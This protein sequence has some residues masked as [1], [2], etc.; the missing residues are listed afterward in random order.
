M[1]NNLLYCKNNKG[2]IQRD[3]Y[4]DILKGI[5]II[6]VVIGHV[7]QLGNDRLSVT[8]VNFIYS[9]HMPLFI[10][11]SGYFSNFKSKSYTKSIFR[12]LETFI[13]I[14]LI[15]S[16]LNDSINFHTLLTPRFALWY[17]LS[18][19][20]WKIMLLI[21]PNNVRSN[22]LIFITSSIILC[23]ASGLVHIST[24]L[25]FQRTFAFMPFFVVGYL[26]RS[27]DYRQLLHRIN[28]IISITACIFAFVMLFFINTNFLTCFSGTTFLINN[29]GGYIISRFL[30]LLCGSVMSISIMRISLLIK[31]SR[32]LSSIG[33]ASLHIY[34]F[35]TFFYLYL[36]RPLNERGFLPN[37]FLY[38][39]LYSLTIIAVLYLTSKVKLF[40]MIVNPI[41]NLFDIWKNRF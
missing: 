18:L 9:F 22:V 21:L 37:T 16:V 6:L 25:S 15:H 40:N 3:I 29:L 13:V 34:I 35:H 2:E 24:V 17:L 33:Q 31:R 38:L 26:L 12:L 10:L 14:Q 20:Y 23:F 28:C 1:N 4:F 36:F 7:L 41:S 39:M 32:L 11:V 8:M 19:V 5:L 30:I 27:Y